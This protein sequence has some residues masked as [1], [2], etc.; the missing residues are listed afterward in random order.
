MYLIHGACVLPTA[1]QRSV[2]MPPSIT[3]P[4]ACRIVGAVQITHMVW[5]NEEHSLV[6]CS[7]DKTLRLAMTVNV[8]RVVVSTR[9]QCHNHV[10]CVCVCVYVLVR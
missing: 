3:L 9:Y 5:P 2:A 1:C 7:E 6:Q 8:L 4:S 10:L